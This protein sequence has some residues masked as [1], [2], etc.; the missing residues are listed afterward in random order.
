MILGSRKF[1]ICDEYHEMWRQLA[2]EE[3]T[4]TEFLT[5]YQDPDN[6]QVEDP[7]ANSSHKH[8]AK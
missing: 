5:A 1:C 2:Q 7:A 4:Y 6:Y 3:I 8:E